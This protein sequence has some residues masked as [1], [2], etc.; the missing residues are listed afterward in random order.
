MSR[1][2]VYF[3]TALVGSAGVAFA[4]ANTIQQFYNITGIALFSTLLVAIAGVC[5]YELARKRA[6]GSA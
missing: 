5:V 2:I 4:T 1:F 6:G 3:A